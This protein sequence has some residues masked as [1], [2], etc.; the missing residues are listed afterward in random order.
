MKA[1]A[2]VDV[3]VCECPHCEQ[4]IVVVSS[5][6]RNQYR[7]AAV[8]LIQYDEGVVGELVEMIQKS[9]DLIRYE[10]KIVDENR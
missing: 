10:G 5:V 8:G 6:P 2:R 7:M 1:D 3:T 9:G 4:Q